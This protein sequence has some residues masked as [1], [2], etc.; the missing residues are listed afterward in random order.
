LEYYPG[1][2]RLRIEMAKLAERL[3]KTDVAI[4]NYKRALE[5]EDSYRGQFEIMYPGRKIFSRL[6][7]EKY[8][9]A[10]QRIESLSQRNED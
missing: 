9:L 2:D 5:I 10:K 3:G 8:Q 7:E 1:S 4:A 6:G